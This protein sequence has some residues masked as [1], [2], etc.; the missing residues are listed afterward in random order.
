MMRLQPWIRSQRGTAFFLAIIALTLLSLLGLSVSFEGLSELTISDNFESDTE[1]LLLAD[2]GLNHAR[3]ELRG[4][5]DPNDP[6]DEVGF[7]FLLRGP[8]ATADPQGTGGFA[9]R[10]P[11]TFSTARLMDPAYFTATITDDGIL[12]KRNAAG[13]PVRVIPESGIVQRAAR[14]ADGKYGTSDDTL[15]LQNPGPDQILDTSDD[16]FMPP[17]AYTSGDWIM[18]RYFLK[19]T[20]DDQAPDEDG[21][22]YD[23]ANGKVI[24]RSM[25]IRNSLAMASRPRRNSVAVVEAVLSRDLSL[26]LEGPLTI[27]ATSVNSAVSGNAFE[28]NGNDR[29]GRKPAKPGVGFMLDNPPSNAHDPAIDFYNS[30]SQQQK[31]NIRGAASNIPEITD[32]SIGDVT[33]ETQSGPNS[34]LLDPNE[35]AGL[36]DKLRDIAKADGTY[37]GT[38]QTW[39]GNNTRFGAPDD[40]R[41]TFIDGSLN[42]S[43]NATGKGILV[44]T[45]DANLSGGAG[46]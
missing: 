41:I 29:S 6:N 13:N 26:E 8:N 18:G 27:E 14:G 24:V 19:V 32:T 37:Y 21:N 4:L 20:D 10:N 38:D 22:A 31:N 11:L 5:Y 42:L 17:G 40:P 39:S 44:V 33:T 23:D 43:G 15:Y 3:E 16:T 2:T 36:I 12:W 7:D 34:V 46:L 28:L 30:L 25:A 1:A 35:L 9:A 45:G